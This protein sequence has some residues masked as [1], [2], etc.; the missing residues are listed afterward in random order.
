MRLL[1]VL[2]VTLLLAAVPAQAKERLFVEVADPYIELHT[3]P[4]RGFP[5][6]HVIP[7]GEPV[8]LLKRRTDWIKVEDE[9]GRS[10]WVQRDQIRRTEDEFG[11]R[12]EVADANREQYRRY[13]W[14]MG[15]LGGDFAGADG[16]GVYGAWRFTPNLTLQLGVTQALGEFSEN[17]LAEVGLIHSPVPEW[18]ISP[19]FGLGTGVIRTDPAATLVRT[20]DRLDQ[21]AHV[22]AGVRVHLTRQLMFRAEY[23]DYVVFTSRNDNEELQLWQAGIAFFF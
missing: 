2:V 20:E 18:R 12:L 7:R 23:R 1:P 6:F 4:G 3:A 19:Y 13:R 22:A 21:T 14:E 10:G 8:T 11:R 17:A 16:I 5:I 9:R 15:V